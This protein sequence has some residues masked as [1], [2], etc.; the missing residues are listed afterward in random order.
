MTA[1]TPLHS[2]GTVGLLD[3]SCYRTT[4][5][6]AQDPNLIRFGQNISVF[7]NTLLLSQNSHGNTNKAL[8]VWVWLGLFSFSRWE[9]G[10]WMKVVN[11]K[12]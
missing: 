8:A 10:V 11:E 1:A 9:V 5:G 4:P 3:F 12:F 7:F 2:Q 6:A